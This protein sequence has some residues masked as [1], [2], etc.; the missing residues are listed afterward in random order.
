MN[1]CLYRGSHTRAPGNPLDYAR[2]AEAMRET[3]EQERCPGC[4]RWVIWKPKEPVAESGHL[5]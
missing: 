3:H 1:E 4:G 5:R 2:W